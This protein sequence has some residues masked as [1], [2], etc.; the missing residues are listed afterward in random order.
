MSSANAQTFTK[1][2]AFAPGTASFSSDVNCSYAFTLAARLLNALILFPCLFFP[3]RH[4]FDV[5]R[6]T[7][8]YF[9]SFRHPSSKKNWNMICSFRISI[10]VLTL[11]Q[12]CRICENNVNNHHVCSTTRWWLPAPFNNIILLVRYSHWV[13]LSVKSNTLTPSSHLSIRGWNE[14]NNKI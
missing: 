4:L 14:W 10:R 1:L 11:K 12:N 5:G 6:F 3:V 9:S 7:E 13:H 8:I 2:T